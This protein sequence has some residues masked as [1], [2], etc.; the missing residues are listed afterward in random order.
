MVGEVQQ[1]VMFGNFVRLLLPALEKRI[2]AV[3]TTVVGHERGDI[4]AEVSRIQL[5][6]T[7]SV[8]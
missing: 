8:V 5:G 6:K 7:L 3:L 1:M 2:E 4:L